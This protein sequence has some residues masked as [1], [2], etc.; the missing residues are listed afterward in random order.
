LV[1]VVLVLVVGLG[2]WPVTSGA[3]GA[4]VGSSSRCVVVGV[5]S[6]C[7]V[8][9]SIAWVRGREGL[10]GV[11]VVRLVTTSPLGLVVVAIPVVI[12]CSIGRG[13]GELE[14]RVG[15]SH[16]TGRGTSWLRPLHLNL[17][18]VNFVILQF[19]NFFHIVGRLEHNKSETFVAMGTVA[20]GTVAIGTVVGR[21]RR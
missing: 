5:A 15:V 14:G 4:R 18:P 20:I 19:Q 10:R 3:L 7:A 17:F 6:S 9:L 16:S 21:C 12:W 13:V 8:L 2:V 11:V 1:V